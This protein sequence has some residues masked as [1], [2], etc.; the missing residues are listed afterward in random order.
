MMRLDKLLTARGI[1]SRRETP[2]LIASGAVSEID[3]LPLK[4]DAKVIPEKIRV[5]GEPL[6]G[7]LIYIL[8][9]K[10]ENTVCSHEDR[11]TLVYE[12]LPQ[13]FCRRSGGI[14]C[15]GRLDKDTTGALLITDDGALNHKLLSPKQHVRKVYEVWTEE[16]VSQERAELFRAGG[17]YLEGD[18]KPLK[19]AEVRLLKDGEV[20]E[21]AEE[22]E[23][24]CRLLLTLTEGRYHQIKRMLEA[25]GSKVVRLHRRSFAGLQLE[26]LKPG[27]WRLLEAEEV[28]RLKGL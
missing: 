7:E 6:D 20:A 27:R 2:R 3:G 18:P 21:E 16:P 8:L 11:G 4:P 1:C 24:S 26:G 25:V 12:L 10:P 22:P 19:A 13:R 23:L 5:N 28:L 9:N 17:L 15:V 14:S